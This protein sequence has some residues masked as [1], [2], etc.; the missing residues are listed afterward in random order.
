MK[1]RTSLGRLG[2]FWWGKI[3]RGRLKFW[4][5]WGKACMVC[6]DKDTS[7]HTVWAFHFGPLEIEWWNRAD[8]RSFCFTKEESA[9]EDA[10]DRA[11]MRR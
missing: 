6:A 7:V 11:A 9:A 1:R 10:A 5:Q 4:R 3:G 8:W 2:F